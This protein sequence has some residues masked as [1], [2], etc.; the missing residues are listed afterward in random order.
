MLIDFARFHFLSHSLI[1]DK[2]TKAD[3][4]HL[5]LKIET[6]IVHNDENSSF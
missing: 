4:Q 1:L 6:H 5:T 2:Y 3:S